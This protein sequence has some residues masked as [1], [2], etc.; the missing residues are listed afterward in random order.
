MGQA[1]TARTC[2]IQ[3]GPDMNRLTVVTIAD[4]AERGHQS[5]GSDLVRE[6]PRRELDSVVGMNDSPGGWLTILDRH[7]E[8]VND[9]G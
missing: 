5:G 7:V 1:V 3:C 9:Q 8:C 6:R 2:R 4:R